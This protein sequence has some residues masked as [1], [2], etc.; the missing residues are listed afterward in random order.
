MLK[1]YKKYTSG[2]VP[3][4]VN[5]DNIV[6]VATR[7]PSTTADASPMKSDTSRL[8]GQV[9][10]SVPAPDPRSIAVPGANTKQEPPVAPQEETS[11]QSS[12][13]SSQ[14]VQQ[15]PTQQNVASSST[16]VVRA[17]SPQPENGNQLQ[18]P[19]HDIRKGPQPLDTRQGPQPSQMSS[20]TS[21]QPPPLSSK[22]S[23]SSLQGPLLAPKGDS[24]AHKGPTTN[25][26]AQLQKK[27]SMPLLNSGISPGAYA[28]AGA[29]AT[30]AAMG[31]VANKMTPGGPPRR[32]SQQSSSSSGSIP[33]IR[34]VSS[35]GPSS[36][37]KAVQARLQNQMAGA[38]TSANGAQSVHSGGSSSPS[39]SQT[40]LPQNRP[41]SAVR[42]GS[43]SAASQPSQQSQ[44]PLPT[45]RQQLKPS[46]QSVSSPDLTHPVPE[47]LV[48]PLDS[49]T[50][51]QVPAA[52]TDLAQPSPRSVDY[53]TGNA[54]ITTQTSKAADMHNKSKEE[55]MHTTESDVRV[56][57]TLAGAVINRQTPSPVAIVTTVDQEQTPLAVT[58]SAP[59]Q[60]VEMGSDDESKIPGPSTS[61]PELGVS[62]GH[63]RNRSSVQGIKIFARSPSPNIQPEDDGTVP[64]DEDLSLREQNDVVNKDLTEQGHTHTFTRGHKARQPS[65]ASNLSRASKTRR[66]SMISNASA[67]EETLEDFNWNGRED[68]ETLERNITRELA[69]IEASNLHNVVDLD[70]RLD[71]LER[72]LDLAVNECDKIGTTLG[73]FSVQLGSFGDDIA[74]IEGQGQ[75]LQVQTTNQ[76]TLWNDLNGLLQTVSLPEERLQVLRECGYDSPR[77]LALLEATA[78][79]LYRAVQTVRAENG[80]QSGYLGNL[81]ALR[82]K[83]HVYDKAA[84]E[85]ILRTRTYLDRKFKLAVQASEREISNVQ[86]SIDDPRLVR[87]DPLTLAQ[88]YPLS[89]VILFV[90][91]LDHVNYSSIVKGYDRVLREYYEVSISSFLA[92]WKRQL[93]ALI[94]KYEQFS[95]TG[96]K[97]NNAVSEGLVS[98]SLK[99]SG[100]I[101]RF[102][103]SASSTSLSTDASGAKG[104][105]SQVSL[106]DSK[107]IVD[108][109]DRKLVQKALRKIFDSLT[110]LVIGEQEAF[111]LLFHESS[112]DSLNFPSFAISNPVANRSKPPHYYEKL[113]TRD[114]DPDYSKAQ[115]LASNVGTIFDCLFDQTAKFLDDYLAHF[116]LGSPFLLAVIDYYVMKLDSTN[117]DFLSQVLVKLKDRIT[118]KWQAFINQ[119]I[120]IINSTIVSSKKRKGVVPFVRKFPLF[121]NSIE[122]DLKN[123]SSTDS[124]QNL[125]VRKVIDS[126]YDKVSKAIFHNLERLAKDTGTSQTNGTSPNITSANN[127]SS[128]LT[129][130]NDFE[131]KELLNYHVMMI[132]NMNILMESLSSMDNAS[133]ESVA[134]TARTTYRKELDLYIQTVLHRPVGKLLDFIDGF[135][136][137][138]DK[139]PNENPTHRHGYSKSS[140]RKL[141][142]SYDSK[143]VR[144][145]IETL[146]KRVEKHFAGDDEDPTFSN[147][148]GNRKLLD[149]VWSATQASYSVL[150]GDLVKIESKYYLDSPGEASQIEFS[151]NDIVTSFSKI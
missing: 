147:N 22:K 54:K 21:K 19:V 95:Y 30:A 45:A 49:E 96:N 65:S 115:E 109:A 102:K 12:A 94:S 143:E 103:S 118:S 104:A 39:S 137:I 105:A 114:I 91:D 43:V 60:A 89:G 50:S 46:Q 27:P 73:V 99:R 120:G 107:G 55:S 33:Q 52:R 32:P 69:H 130:A 74:H 56:G 151:K 121:A 88:L 101:A 149:K 86:Q 119:Q 10:G 117:Q 112:F 7:T 23:L 76:K 108:L 136:A 80:T 16:A 90:K 150:Y 142:S 126:S 44:P 87:I 57:D 1:I 93:S 28:A 6:D 140:F 97:E 51:S 110:S 81:R 26:P 139:N 24:V 13:R 14:Q 72:S 2:R 20:A 3:E 83:K 58:K 127:S 70:E 8:P 36:N 116:S 62:K 61:T 144:K 25:P 34:K 111:T 82:E 53:S 128:N 35:S 138:V 133:L 66:L 47:S 100:T 75:G 141:I 134:Y 85:F 145:G 122:E 17:P 67:V 18:A 125:P 9:S 29:A 123:V 98:K 146:R 41:S 15:Q 135:N 129:T 11:K 63:A 77:E 132:E 106:E 79:D 59:T 5:L 4:L 48:R 68:V 31:N 42:Q 64:T 124:V 131:D 71:E 92:K 37:V 84:S 113:R 148:P 78:V 38:S 40:S